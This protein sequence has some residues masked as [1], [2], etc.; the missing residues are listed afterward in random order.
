[1]EWPQTVGYN[2][3]SYQ[4]KVTCYKKK[5][6]RLYKTLLFTITLTLIHNIMKYV[7]TSSVVLFGEEK[8]I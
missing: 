5:I 7:F 2:S 1:M 6:L 4:E 8:N 3:D